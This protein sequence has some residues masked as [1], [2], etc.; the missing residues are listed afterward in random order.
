M[1]KSLLQ[2]D[3]TEAAF[4]LLRAGLGGNPPTGLP[5]LEKKA[6]ESILRWA[7]EHT[8]SGILYQGVTRLG[9]DYPLPTE[10][11]FTLVARA[12]AISRESR[13]HQEVAE[14][15]L[16]LFRTRGL[17]PVLM[18][19]PSVAALYPTPL[20]RVCGDLDFYFPEQEY[21]QAATA[22][23]ARDARP[24]GRLIHTYRGVEIDL[25]RHYFDLHVRELPPVPSP[26]ATFLMLSSHIL[27]H[28]VGAGVGMRQ[29]CDMAMAYRHLEYDPEA[30][31]YWY[32]KTGTERWNRLLSSFL[33]EKLD[34]PPLYEDLPSP[35]PLLRIVLEGG[36]FGQWGKARKEAIIH[37]DSLRRK[38]NTLR[39]F[40]HHIPFSFRY[41]PREPHCPEA[42]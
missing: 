23:Q 10:V 15:L 35:D 20:L 29:L 38:G 33:A 41:A 14:E 17:H 6:W 39:L 31:R 21:L 34:V 2:P 30:L 18:K 25:H 7:Q 36:N 4:L 5:V 40:L 42:R 28:C 22:I 16:G 8:V 32:R 19:G 11:L 24:D 13:L 37:Q 12:D 1:A 9:K 27:K 3:L 26:E